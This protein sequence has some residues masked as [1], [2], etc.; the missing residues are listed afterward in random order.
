VVETHEK[1]NE[2]EHRSENLDDRDKGD[3]DQDHTLLDHIL[4]RLQPIPKLQTISELLQDEMD[5]MSRNYRSQDTRIKS[6]E[7]D[8]R[9]IDERHVLGLDNLHG[10]YTSQNER[11]KSLER[12][13]ETQSDVLS[14][15][16]GSLAK[17]E[18]KL[19]AVEERVSKEISNMRIDK[20]SQNL[21]ASAGKSGSYD[22]IKARCRKVEERLMTL[23]QRTTAERT[24]YRLL[25]SNTKYT[26]ELNDGVNTWKKQCDKEYSE[27]KLLKEQVQTLEER[28]SA[29][30]KMIRDQQGLIV[31]LASQ[32]RVQRTSKIPEAS[33]GDF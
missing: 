23:D 32:L 3:E 22:K 19:I 31:E 7:T 28:S 21:D 17:V 29:M 12:A 24:L 8:L 6:L 15:T 13:R 18:A 14:K 4:S 5:T 9:T 16:E 25:D 26:R 1:E 33:I 11:V 27:A 30:E 10:N 2:G 20:Q